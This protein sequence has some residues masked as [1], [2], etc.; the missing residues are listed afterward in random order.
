MLMQLLQREKEAG[1]NPDPDIDMFMK[2]WQL[3]SCFFFAS[4][5]FSIIISIYDFQTLHFG[6]GHCYSRCGVK[7]FD[8]LYN[9]GSR[10]SLPNL[11]VHGLW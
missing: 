11:L 10:L 2:V 4:K 6:V 3:Q 1:I 5:V 9:E 8:R 7:S